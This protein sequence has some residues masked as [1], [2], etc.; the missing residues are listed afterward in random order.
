MIKEE[1]NKSSIVAALQPP[2]TPVPNKTPPVTPTPVITPS[3]TI[4]AAAVGTLASAF[5]D[6]ST[7]VQLNSILNC[8]RR[9]SIY[10]SDDTSL[11]G[12]DNGL[13]PPNEHILALVEALSNPSE[14]TMEDPKTEL[15]SHANIIVL[16]KH[17]FVF[18]WS[19]KSCTVNTF[20]DCLGHRIYQLSM[21]PL[22]MTVHN[23]TKSTYSYD[24]TPFTNP[25]WSITNSLCLSCEKVGLH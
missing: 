9:S 6:L 21:L 12:R 17:F 18:E 23:L 4:A 13:D 22:R 3:L 11:E 7:K 5:T 15:D 8:N 19:G 10:F 14:T 20:N 25:A 16:G 2:L 24:A 1:T